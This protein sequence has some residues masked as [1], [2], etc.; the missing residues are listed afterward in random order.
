MPCQD[1][2][3]HSTRSERQRSQPAYASS[4]MRAPFPAST[5]APWERKAVTSVLGRAEEVQAE[6]TPSLRCGCSPRALCSCSTQGRRGHS[7]P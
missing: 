4:L 6:R 7:T 3:L 1:C 5:A 2:R